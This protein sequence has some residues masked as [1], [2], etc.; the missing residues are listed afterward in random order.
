MGNSPEICR[1]HYAALLPESLV[2]CVEFPNVGAAEEKQKRTH[3][4]P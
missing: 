3:E 2:E 4:I 1:K